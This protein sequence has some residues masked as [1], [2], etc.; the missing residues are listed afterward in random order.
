MYRGVARADKSYAIA[1][2]RLFCILIYAVT[3][4]DKEPWGKF[5]ARD[6]HYAKSQ[7]F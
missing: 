4:N 2:G 7:D 3:I 5:E 6:R 1:I